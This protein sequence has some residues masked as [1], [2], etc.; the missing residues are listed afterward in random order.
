MSEHQPLVNTVEFDL[1]SGYMDG[2]GQMHKHVV[3][4]CILNGD[5]IAYHS[6]TEMR[7]MA[8]SKYRIDSG[9]PAEMMMATAVA[10][11]MDNIMYART[12]LQFGSLPKE[13]ITRKL[14]EKLFESDVRVIQENYMRLNGFDKTG[15]EGNSE[16]APFGQLAS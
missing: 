4:R 9:N 12:I 3:M 11:K 2:D 5:I 7:E 1:P 16:K 6:D 10:H 8:T 15:K 13:Q 14:F